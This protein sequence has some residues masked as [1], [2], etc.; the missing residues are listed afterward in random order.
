MTEDVMKDILGDDFDR[1]GEEYEWDYELL[2]KE[3]VGRLVAQHLVDRSGIGDEIRFISDKM[4]NKMRDNL[5]KGSEETIDGFLREMD[6]NVKNFVNQTL[7]QEDIEMF[8][9][10]AVNNST[11]QLKHIDDEIKSLKKLVDESYNIMAKRVKIKQIQDKTG[12]QSKYDILEFKQLH[13]QVEQ[14][15]YTSATV[16]FLQYVQ[17]DCQQ[18][19]EQLKELKQD[20]KN[21]Y[22]HGLP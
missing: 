10:E 9:E 12:K 7:G 13:S 19:L 1:Y 5:R 4:L 15:E 8:D 11:V 22:V 21:G 17:S 2:Q 18:V 16:Q 20:N 3:A 6:D 14:G